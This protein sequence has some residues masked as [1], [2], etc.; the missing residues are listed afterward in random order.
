MIKRKYFKSAAGKE[1]L[2]TRE[3]NYIQGS[4][5]K[6]NISFLDRN[7][8]NEN[9]MVKDFSAYWN[10][11]RILHSAKYIFQKG[12]QNKKHFQTWKVRIYYQQ[13]HIIKYVKGSRKKNNIR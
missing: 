9:A 6:H 7:N 13:S 3:Q 5:D 12:K 4:K 11:L 2:H 1:M 10:R 8:A